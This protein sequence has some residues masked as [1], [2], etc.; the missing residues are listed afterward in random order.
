[1]QIT[2]VV[3]F[4]AT[5]L[6]LASG[7]SDAS[8]RRNADTGPLPAAA[9]AES[10]GR[11]NA[12]GNPPETIVDTTTGESATDSKTVYKAII[13]RYFNA[14]MKADLDGLLA[15]LHPG[16]PMYPKRAAIQQL[17]STASGNALPGEAVV[18]SIEI[19]EEGESKA[20]V[21]ATLFM[22]ADIHKNGNFREETSHPTCE[23]R[24]YDGQW[25]LFSA[26]T[27]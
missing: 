18:K 15:S 17:R 5:A 3:M 2:R 21:K 19:L 13:E 23:L 14:Y 1:M 9:H 27:R 24:K 25:R 20:R 26:T 6:S 11:N 8:D 12:A 7:C 4:I 16:G 22:R 10:A